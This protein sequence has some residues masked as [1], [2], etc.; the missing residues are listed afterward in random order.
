MKVLNFIAILF[1]IYETSFYL[2]K[3]Q[4]VGQE[5]NDCTKIY[6]FMFIDKNI[7]DNN[8]CFQDARIECDNEGYIT[9]FS[10]SATYFQDLSSFPYLERIKELYINGI[11]LIEIPD[12]IFKLTSL[13]TLDLQMNNIQKIPASIQN[14]SQLENL[15]ISY[16]NIDELP[17]EIYNLTKLKNFFFNSNPNLKAKIINFGTSSLNECQFDAIN[18]SCYQPL[19]CK[20]IKSNNMEFNDVEAEKY[21]NICTKEEVDEILGQIDNKKDLNLD[22]I[23]NRD[24]SNTNKNDDSNLNND[25]DSNSTDNDSNSKNKKWITLTLIISSIVIGCI[26]ILLAI[27]VII[28]KKRAQS[29]EFRSDSFNNLLKDQPIKID[30]NNNGINNNNELSV[31]INSDLLKSPNLPEKALRLSNFKNTLSLLFNNK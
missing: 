21:V 18:V 25:D 23:K 9:K 6:N 29:N 26:V 20:N 12:N 4:T 17:N 24:N 13:T 27:I 1:L 22:D 30:N 19:T 2:V 15:Y 11:G 3:G 7:Y 10:N 14:L 31:I 16:N 8:C 28:K 5:K